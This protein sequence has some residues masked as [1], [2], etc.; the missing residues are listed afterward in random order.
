[1]FQRRFP[2]GVFRD[3]AVLPGQGETCGTVRLYRHGTRRSIHGTARVPNGYY[4]LTG[5]GPSV[6]YRNN[7]WPSSRRGRPGR[8]F[9]TL[10]ISWC[11]RGVFHLE[12]STWSKLAFLFIARVRKARGPSFSTAV[13]TW[14]RAG[15]LFKSHLTHAI[16]CLTC[17]PA[18][19]YVTTSTV[20][21]T[22]ANSPS[23][24]YR[25]AGWSS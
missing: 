18:L 7:R 21:Y 19:S 22:R 24:A 5:D 20:R 4:A 6:A 11:S 9:I 10:F 23:V 8:R 14:R 12:F 16:R 13:G 25:N 1:M 17:V 3:P 15:E 2:P